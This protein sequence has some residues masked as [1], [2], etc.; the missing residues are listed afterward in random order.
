M[1][2]ALSMYSDEL[3][4]MLLSE[5]EISEELIHDIVRTAVI[6]QEFTPVYLG[7]AYRNKGVQ[8]LLDA[9]VR[10]L[11]SPLESPSQGQGPDRPGRR[12]SSSS[13]IR[14]SRSS[15]WRSR[16]SK[17]SSA[18]SRSPAIY[19]G[20]VEKGGSYFNQRTGKKD[21]FSRIVKMHADKREEIDSAEAGDIVAIMGIDCASGDTYCSEPKYCT[22]EN[23]FVAKPVIKM[24]ITPI[25]ARQRRPA[26]QG[27]AAVPQGRPDVQVITD[28]ETSETVI[29]G[30]GELHLEIYVER[31][32]R[33]YKVEV[34]VGAPKVSY[35]ESATKPVAYDFKHKKQ[36][37]GSGQYAHIVGKMGPMTDEEVAETE[38]ELLFVDKVVGGRIPKNFIPA[39]EKGFRNMLAKGPVAG[40]P[41]VGMKIELNDGKYHEVDS[42]DMAFM[43]CA[44]NCFR[45]TFPKMKPALLEPIMLMEIEVPGEFPR[46]GGGQHL[47][48]PRHRDVDRHDQRHHEDHR[49]SAAGRDVRLLDR[50]ALDDARPGHVHD[51][52]VEV[53]PGAGEH[54]DRNHRRAQGRAAAGVSPLLADTLKEPS[55]PGCAGG[56]LLAKD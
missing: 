19:Q 51:G 37:G 10:Y 1:L 39:I 14:T 38:G 55:T 43:V 42:S 29:A 4:E 20:K 25:V 33:E 50:P 22:L 26:G 54:P 48:P 11:P 6:E 34:E 23:M 40:F 3:M 9:I 35:R 21:R 44:Q 15:A 31:I 41:V 47:G 8:P 27:P 5:E 28:E 32:R 7:T 53:P 17:M 24:S 30:M 56:F 45:E 13:P 49:R 46:H 16:S 2:E 52:A 18:S 36:T 12:S